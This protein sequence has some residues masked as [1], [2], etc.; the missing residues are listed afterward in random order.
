MG[1]M[2]ESTPDEQMEIKSQIKPSTGFHI[3]VFTLQAKTEGPK[4]EKKY[5]MLAEGHNL[6]GVGKG[7][8]RLR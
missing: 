3:S 5:C 8:N 6:L 4:I 1:S 7:E 2:N